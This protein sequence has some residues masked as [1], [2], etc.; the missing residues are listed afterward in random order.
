M[1]RPGDR[2]AHTPGMQARTPTPEQ[3]EQL[4]AWRALALGRM[5]YMASYLFN[6]RVLDAPGLGTFA[7]DPGF[8]MY[9]DFDAVAAK[10]ADWC[11]E[12]LLH[13]VGH[14]FGEHHVFA[15]DVGVQPQHRKA[16]NVS[17]DLA[18]ND[19]LVE[20]G[21]LTLSDMIPSIVGLPDHLTANDYFLRL[22]QMQPPQS[23]EHDGPGGDRPEQQS[24]SGDAHGQQP[25]QGGPDGCGD[26]EPFAGCGSASG[27]D[28]APC[29]LGDD[30]DLGGQA[31]AATTGEKARVRIA[32]AQMIVEHASRGRGTVPNG[33]LAQAHMVLTP[34]RT[35]WQRLVGSTLRRALRHRSG[36][37]MPNY[38]AR[39]RRRHDIRLSPAGPK[40]IFPGRRAPKLRMAVVRDT[41]GS[42]GQ[43]ELEA[44][45]REIVTIARKLRIRGD[46]LVVLDVDAAVHSATRFRNGK[47][48]MQVR[49]RGGTDMVAGIEQALSTRGGVDVVAVL[50]DGMTPWPQAPTPVP[51]VACLVGAHAQEAAQ[52]VPSWIKAVVVDDTP[53]GGAR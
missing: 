11:S 47:E 17:C 52:E 51:V 35:P 49:G 50:T 19:D 9:I 34:T 29:E 41:S 1:V 22:V 43:Q 45:T 42:M 28:V 12:A 16:W 53:A 36:L 10:G 46:D 14:L 2:P 33:L 27:G 4:S 25:D 5:P 48:L 24:D 40:V 18:L 8:R 6:V 15:E 3:Y 39:D 13:E 21:C 30:D 32:T 20:A 23:G 26:Q 38:T 31:P 7:V 44:V 37:T